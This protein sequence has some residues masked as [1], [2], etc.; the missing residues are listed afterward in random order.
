[1]YLLDSPHFLVPDNF[2]RFPK[3]VVQVPWKEMHIA[4]TLRQIKRVF[5]VRQKCD[6]D[7]FLK[8]VY[9]PLEFSIIL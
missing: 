5:M 9:L 8:A 4:Q 6:T 2:Y 1:M 7:E 3:I